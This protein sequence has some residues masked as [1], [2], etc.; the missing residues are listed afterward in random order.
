M[1]AMTSS[2]EDPGTASLINDVRRAL[3]R[4]IPIRA[5]NLDQLE[6]EAH[7]NTVQLRGSV[8]SPALRYLADQAARSVHGVEKVVNLLITDEELERDIALALSSVPSLRKRR[9]AVNATGGVVGL[10][11]AVSSE[12]EAEACRDLALRVPGVVGVES[13]LHILQLNQ[14]VVLTWQRSLEGRPAPVQPATEPEGAMESAGQSAETGS[15][16]SPPPAPAEA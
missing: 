5:L 15:A 1:R 16:P 12:E 2:K 4:S 13:K 8:A 6:I 11:G 9:I 7:G 14:P 10:Y 3:W